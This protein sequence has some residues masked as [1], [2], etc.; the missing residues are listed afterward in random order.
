MAVSRTAASVRSNAKA[1]AEKGTAPLAPG[2]VADRLHKSIC[3]SVTGARFLLNVL[4]QRVQHDA[5]LRRQLKEV[6]S[7]LGECSI[8]LRALIKELRSEAEKDCV[9]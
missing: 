2:T 4:E 1:A 3:Q 9:T 7:V 6:E 8:E 5:E